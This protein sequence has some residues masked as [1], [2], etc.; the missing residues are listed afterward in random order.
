MSANKLNR[1]FNQFALFEI[2]KAMRSCLHEMLLM[3]RQFFM[4]SIISGALLL[5]IL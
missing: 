2:E 3:L 5:C 1:K 4:L